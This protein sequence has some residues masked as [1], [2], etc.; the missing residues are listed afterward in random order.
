[1]G[2]ESFITATTGTLHINT[3]NDEAGWESVRVHYGNTT[4]KQSPIICQRCGKRP[5]MKAG[6]CRKCYNPGIPIRVAKKPGR[7]EPCQ[8]GSGR[9]RKWCCK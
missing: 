6:L 5:E 8:C 4:A 7:N 9:K 3:T 2:A 1:M